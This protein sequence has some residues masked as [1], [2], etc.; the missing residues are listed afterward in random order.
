MERWNVVRWA[1][2]AAAAAVMALAPAAAWA[3]ECSIEVE[4]LVA[5]DDDCDGVADAVDGFVD[6]LTQDEEGCVVY[7]FCVTNT[8]DLSDPQAIDLVEVTDSRMLF[9]PIDFGT[10]AIGATEC[11]EFP[12]PESESSLLCE[13]YEGVNTATITS[14]ICGEDRD[15]ACDRALSDCEDTAEVRCEDGGEGCLTRTPGYLANH[16]DV[17]A[18]LLAEVGPIASCGSNL[19]VPTLALCPPGR[20]DGPLSSQQ[21]QLRRQCAAAAL[22][23]SLTELFGGDCGEVLDPA[24]F[25]ACCGSAAVCGQVPAGCIDDVTGFNES[26]DTLFEDLCVELGGGPPCDAEPLQCGAPNGSAFGKPNR[27]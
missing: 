17:V 27:R 16:P 25:A 21:V 15:D 10:V 20:D 12:Y 3:W 18:A 6:V 4:K 23:F 26:E 13:D 1:A 8:S 5:P 14:A 7:Q 24:R 9:G 19:A 22:N 2:A 11:I